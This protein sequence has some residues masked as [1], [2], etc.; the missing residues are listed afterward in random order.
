MCLLLIRSK[1]PLHQDAIGSK[2][3]HM[4]RSIIMYMTLN[5]HNLP[6]SQSCKVVKVMYAGGPESTLLL[7]TTEQE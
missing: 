5:Y 7:A 6:A 3:L 2:N 4:E 1:Q